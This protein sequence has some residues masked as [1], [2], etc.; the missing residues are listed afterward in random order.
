MIGKTGYGRLLA[1]AVLVAAGA[2][3]Q[4]APV[5]PANPTPAITVTVGSN[6]TITAVA[7]TEYTDNTPI[8]ATAVATFTLYGARAATVGATPALTPEATGL[9]SPTFVQSSVLLGT[10]CYYWTET[11]AGIES[12]PSTMVCGLV[13]AAPEQPQA[14]SSP[15]ITL[16][17]AVTP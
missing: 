10:D 14:P 11:I 15:S 6:I 17:P 7:A 13:V 3:A 8:P 9:A 16:S 4:T 2:S 5:F 1:L 12:P